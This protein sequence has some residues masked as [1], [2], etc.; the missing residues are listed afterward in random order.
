M[1]DL[2]K[3]VSFGLSVPHHVLLLNLTLIKLLHCKLSS[4]VDVLNQV[5]LA[6]RPFT[7]Q[8]DWQ[9]V[10]DCDLFVKFNGWLAIFKSQNLIFFL[11]LVFIL[12]HQ[13]LPKFKCIS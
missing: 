5:D 11:Y 8:C 7:Q 1:V 3:N 13:S 2:C 9:K 4:V 10:V 12:L 6:I